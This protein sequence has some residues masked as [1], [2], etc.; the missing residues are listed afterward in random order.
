MTETIPLRKSVLLKKRQFA[1]E[2]C[3]ISQNRDIKLL[4]EKV[5]C[6]LITRFNFCD[7]SGLPRLIL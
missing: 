1:T 5:F 2:D 6:F 4:I 7:G 3:Q